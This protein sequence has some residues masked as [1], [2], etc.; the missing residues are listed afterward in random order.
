[1]RKIIY[2]IITLLTVSCNE[3]PNAE[4][5]LSGM[6]NGIENGTVLYLDYDNKKLDSTVVQN[7]SFK[8]KTKLPNTPMK[9][10]N[11]GHFGRRI[12]L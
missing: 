9:L 11:T 10:P 12:S 4:F 6:T 2:G 1:M 3:K 7:N 8:F 5:S